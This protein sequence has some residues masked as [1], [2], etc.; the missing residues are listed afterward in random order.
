MI[1]ATTGWYV[2]PATI[3]AVVISPDGRVLLARNL[4]GEWEL[5]GGWPT[6]EDETVGDVIRREVAEEASI[7]VD[8]G[9]LLHVELAH[10][11]GHQVVIVAYQC[12]CRSTNNATPSDE[13]RAL[14]WKTSSDLA[15]L[16]LIAPYA[17]AIQLA[18][19]DHL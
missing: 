8:V 9:S 13:H 17:T 14:E 6:R 10:V 16:D 19:G 3:K 1:D 15:N 12:A 18:F 11:G 2:V 5:P 7:E 4:R